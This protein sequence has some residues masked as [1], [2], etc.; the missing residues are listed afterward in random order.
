MPNFQSSNRAARWIIGSLVGA[1]LVAAISQWRHI[2]DYARGP[3]PNVT[4]PGDV[5]R[6]GDVII[7][8]DDVRRALGNRGKPADAEVAKSGVLEDLIRRELLFA[9]AQRSG[10][11]ERD[12]IKAAW[13]KF[14]ASRFQEELEAGEAAAAEVSDGDIAKHYESHLADYSSAE[15]RRLAVIFLPLPPHADEARTAK[16]QSEIRAIRE[17][18]LRQTETTQGFGRL[19][20]ARSAHQASRL[21][22]GDVGWLTRSQ[23]ARA[24]PA[25]VADAAFA[26]SERGAISEVIAADEG[27]YLLK[28]VDLQ[29]SQ[30]L[31][32]EDVRDRI[33]HELSRARVKASED[34]RYAA[35]MA[36]HP[37]EIFSDHP[38]AVDVLRTAL[39]QQP[40]HLPAH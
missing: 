33:R 32:L 4:G 31:P 35:L 9:E 29:A 12:E 27:W 13:R 38:A 28:L 30:P 40:P 3:Q 15:R 20:E 17:T 19:A 1:V 39:A 37:V 24:W 2:R 25:A 8:A 21:H 11:C 5:A 22:G 7:T 36:R 6:V 10:F 23:A 14:I 34:A 16:L 26:L 18:S